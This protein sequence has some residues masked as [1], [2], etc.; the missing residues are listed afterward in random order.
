MGFGVP[1]S[2]G[3]PGIIDTGNGDSVY[4]SNLQTVI[5]LVLA[6]TL[7][8]RLPALVYRISSRDPIGLVVAAVAL[9][10]L[11]APV[12]AARTQ[13]V[14][15]RVVDPGGR[16]IPQAQLQLLPGGPLVTTDSSGSF[17]FGVLADG[18][19]TVI[20]RRLGFQPTT[21]R[22]SVPMTAARLSITLTPV[23]VNLDTVRSEA[24]EKDLP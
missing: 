3:G 12:A 5:D 4:V 11:G 16:P 19:H 1:G 14:G 21:V 15:G 17:G 20:V 18:R 2:D 24:L 7:S 13:A 9:L 23:P 22:L 6:L 10:C 8:P